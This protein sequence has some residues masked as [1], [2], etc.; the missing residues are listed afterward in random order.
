[1]MKARDGNDETECMLS[2]KG[3]GIYLK[4]GKYIYC[5]HAHG[6]RVIEVRGKRVY[7]QCSAMQNVN[8]H[9]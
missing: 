1:M 9:Y 4:S 3:I 8:I 2:K 6:L 5:G 7:A